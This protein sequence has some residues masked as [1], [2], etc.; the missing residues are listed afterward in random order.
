MLRG[1]D[2]SGPELC[3]LVKKTATLEYLAIGSCFLHGYYWEDIITTL[4]AETNL[5]DLVMTDI[6]GGFKLDP[7]QYGY[8]WHDYN[9][10]VNQY[11]HGVK[12]KPLTEARWLAMPISTR[13]GNPKLFPCQTRSKI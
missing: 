13:Q 9:N 5:G 10:D 8:G 7:R 2:M 3:S 11:L 4:K 6:H 1:V 12:D